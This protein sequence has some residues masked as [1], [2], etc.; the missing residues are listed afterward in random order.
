MEQPKRVSNRIRSVRFSLGAVL[1]VALSIAGMVR[2]AAAQ[3]DTNTSL[4]SGALG[5][6]T[7]GTDN[8]GLGFDALFEN[9]TGTNNT[10]VGASTLGASV[11]ASYN[12]AIGA[13]A[14]FANS[15]GYSNTATGA[16]ALF[17][18]EGGHSNNAF[19]VQALTENTTGDRNTAIGM[20]ALLQ[21][22]TGSDNIAIGVALIGNTT[23]GGNVAVGDSAL[24]NDTTGNTNIAIGFEAGS[25]LTTGS[26][27]IDIGNAGVAGE[28]GIIRI[29]TQGVHAH[30]VVAGINNTPFFSGSPVLVNS[31]GRLGI[32]VSSARFKRGIRDMG[33]ASNR[34]MKL[35][36]VTF[37]YKKDPAGTVQYG[38]VAEEVAKVYPELVTSGED[39]QPL[40]VDYYKLP[41]MLLNELQKQVRENR[42]KDEQ[43]AALQRQVESL[44][45]EQARI[46]ALAARLSTLEQQTRMTRPER[47]AAARMP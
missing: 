42:Q 19:G 35:R 8:T 15:D 31:F 36:P 20:Q 34:L 9:T 43:I 23:G 46:D 18:N 39:G 11:N 30:V 16:V 32:E 40:S 1:L 25:N 41:A 38:L 3:T 13:S 21:N 24:E 4:G 45:K 17:S 44:H 27:D 7:T 12:T 6:N 5:N 26:N 22:T 10:A 47:L 14:L 28:S 2:A 29:G 33:D 37:R